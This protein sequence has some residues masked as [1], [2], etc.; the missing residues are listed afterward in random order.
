MDTKLPSQPLENLLGFL[1]MSILRLFK[2][3][4]LMSQSSLEILLPF[5]HAYAYIGT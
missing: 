4:L 3:P 2:V 5:R 1:V